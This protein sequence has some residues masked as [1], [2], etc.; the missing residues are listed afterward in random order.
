MA[1]NFCRAPTLGRLYYKHFHV[2]TH[3]IS[4]PG[5]LFYRGG[6]PKKLYRFPNK[7]KVLRGR[8]TIFTQTIWF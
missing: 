5:Q 3:L 2:L 1:A 6:N 4:E 8:D 7:T